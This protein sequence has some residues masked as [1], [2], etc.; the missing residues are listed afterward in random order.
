MKNVELMERVRDAIA[1]HPECH[2]QAT[3]A[4]EGHVTAEQAPECGTSF[5]IA[6]WAIALATGK[7]LN[8]ALMDRNKG[9][10]E[11]SVKFVGFGGYGAELLGLTYEEAL[12]DPDWDEIE[13]GEEEAGLFTT[14]DNDLALK[15]LDRLIEEGKRE[16]DTQAE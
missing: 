3:W 4:T 6:G 14:M 13:D 16:R 1:L 9:V 5:C 8:Q 15:K 11:N 7:S 12:V 10:S 2:N